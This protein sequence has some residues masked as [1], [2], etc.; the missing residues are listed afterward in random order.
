MPRVVRTSTSEADMIEIACYI[1]RDNMIAAERWL[2]TID[3]KLE[4]IAT[5]P[6]IG[7]LRSHLLA[8][9]RTFPVGQYIIF[10]R[11]IENGIE[12][13]RV[14]HGARKLHRKYFKSN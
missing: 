7:R 12:V 11:P 3:E 10:Y 4:L 9:L 14:L 2:D 8:G 5:A 1:A 6:N 13:L